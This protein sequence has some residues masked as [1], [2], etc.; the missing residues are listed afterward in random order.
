MSLT[1]SRAA[2]PR[3]GEDRRCRDRD[4]RGM[5]EPLVTTHNPVSQRHPVPRLVSPTHLITAVALSTT[6]A[7]LVATVPTTASSLLSSTA[8][9]VLA[10]GAAA[11]GQWWPRRLGGAR[12]PPRSPSRERSRRSS[13]ACCCRPRRPWPWP[14]TSSPSRCRS[15][16]ASSSSA[17]CAATAWL[18]GRCWDWRSLR[19]PVALL[20]DCCAPTPSPPC[21]KDWPPA[22]AGP[23]PG[24]CSPWQGWAPRWPGAWSPSICWAPRRRVVA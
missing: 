3:T 2:V 22:S 6:A 19:W 7:V 11:L 12:L 8:A 1:R 4:A 10:V 21:S 24:C 23:G 14:G 13:S 18:G 5:S 17:W 16:S 20:P 15:G 9:T